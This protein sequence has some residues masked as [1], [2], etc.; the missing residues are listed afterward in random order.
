MMKKVLAILFV[1]AMIAC[2]MAGCGDDTTTTVTTTT[3]QAATTTTTTAATTITT[4]SAN[5]GA[6][7]EDYLAEAGIVHL[8]TFLGMESASYVSVVNGIVDCQDYGYEDD[9]VKQMVQTM[10]ISVVGYSDDNKTALEDS[11]KTAFATYEAVDC[12]TVTY[13]MG[14]THFKVRVLYDELDKAENVSALY[15]AG[16]ITETSTFI[17]MSKTDS[18]LAGL[19][20]TKK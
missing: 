12:V 17:S 1:F 20:Y 18:E 2:V 7:Y 9:V 14:N 4:E 6:S 10:Y 5:S 19:G 15:A 8:E 11:M 3:T 13:D 16:L